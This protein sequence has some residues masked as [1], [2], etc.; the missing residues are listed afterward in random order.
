M[1]AEAGKQFLG[2]LIASIDSNKECVVVQNKSD[3]VVDLTGWKLVLSLDQK[4]FTFPPNTEIAGGRNSKLAVWGG[5]K[6]KDRSFNRTNLWWSAAV[7]GLANKDEVA[8]LE[9][10]RGFV[11]SKS[12]GTPLR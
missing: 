11:A 5:K 7:T 12:R 8:S 4:S 9:N 1:T 10:S 3:A 2:V 6:N